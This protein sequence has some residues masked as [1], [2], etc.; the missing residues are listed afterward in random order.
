MKIRRLFLLF[1]AAFLVLSVTAL[2][3]SGPKPDLTVEFEGLEGEAFWVTAL[4]REG[5]GPWSAGREYEGSMGPEEIWER[6]EGYSDA[7]GYEFLGYIQDCSEDGRFR[8]NYYPPEEFRLLLYFPERDSFI[9][10]D[11]TYERYAFHSYFTADLSG[12]QIPENSSEILGFP[13]EQSYNYWSEFGGFGFRIAVTLA[14]ELLLAA[15]F[16]FRRPLQLLVAAAANLATQTGLNLALNA[17]VYYRGPGMSW[18]Y[19]LWMEIAA[20]LL[21]GLLYWY[22]FPRLGKETEGRKLHPW[23][24]A[25]AANAAS[26]AAGLALSAVL[27]DWF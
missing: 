6:F 21:E 15:A 4:G 22:A 24:Y 19:L 14:V 27:P 8:W 7:E 23:L 25:W 10:S 12:V 3:D 2:A 20:A 17:L 26:F 5:S 11:R 16:G 18:F 9:A 1:L 13:V